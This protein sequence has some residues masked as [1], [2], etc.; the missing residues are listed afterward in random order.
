MLVRRLLTGI[1]V[2]AGAHEVALE[3]WRR[4]GLAPPVKA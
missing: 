1:G 4:R 2:V 3:G